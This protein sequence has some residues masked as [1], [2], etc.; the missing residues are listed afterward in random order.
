VT[1]RAKADT[2]TGRPTAI[3]APPT[4]CNAN[5]IDSNSQRVISQGMTPATMPGASAKKRAEPSAGRSF[6]A[7]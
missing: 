6:V 5:G 7:G 3:K 2:R 4:T 1:K